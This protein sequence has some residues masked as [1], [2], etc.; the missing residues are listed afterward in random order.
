VKNRPGERERQTLRHEWQRFVLRN[1]LRFVGA[2]LIGAIIAFIFQIAPMPGWERIYLQGFLTAPILGVIAWCTYLAS[3]HQNL[4]FGKMGEES[5]AQSVLTL[6]RRLQGWR[7]VNGLY[8]D[9]HGDVDHVL[10]GEGGIFAIESKWTNVPWS[11]GGD[12]LVGP[13]SSPTFQARRSARK[14]AS[15]LRSGSDPIDLP[16]MPVVVV[17]GPGAPH[18][19]AGF[20]MV[21]GV[22]V[23]EGRRGQTWVRQLHNFQLDRPTV[24]L[25][26]TKLVAALASRDD[27]GIALRLHT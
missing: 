10:I 4:Y 8:F 19:A 26:T 27:T 24:Q 20:A 23:A 9:A 7:L 21:D 3:G 25:V 11:I 17:W 22:L 5:T 14:V 6:R 2:L 12:K 13:P 1:P 16:V 18:I 15:T